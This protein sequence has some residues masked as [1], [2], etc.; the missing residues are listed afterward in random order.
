M[1]FKIKGVL[2]TNIKDPMTRRIVRTKISE[3]V[4]DLYSN[5]YHSILNDGS[6]G[7]KDA[8]RFLEYPPEQVKTLFSA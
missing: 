6:G 2:E 4:S 5:I 1:I 8:N 7:Y 3:Y